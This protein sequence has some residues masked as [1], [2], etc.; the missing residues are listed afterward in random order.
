MIYIASNGRASSIRPSD[1]FVVHADKYSLYRR[2]G[3]RVFCLISDPDR[4]PIMRI[5]EN[6]QQNKYPSRAALFDD[7]YDQYQNRSLLK[8]GLILF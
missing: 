1:Y 6:I 4:D 5:Y 3:G 8:A 2:V 7:I